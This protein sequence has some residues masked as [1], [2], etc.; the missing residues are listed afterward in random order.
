MVIEER[1][2]IV[3][4]SGTMR[5]NQWPVIRTTAFIV[6]NQYPQEV[7][8]DFS[9]ARWG[10]A[11]GEHTLTAAIDEIERLNLP[12]VLLNV[13]GPIQSRLAVPLERRLSART[14]LWFSRLWGVD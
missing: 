8:I 10:A 9:G 13:A 12:F 11:E 6:L 5:C 4:V 2:N 14:E 1:R 7:I 3:S